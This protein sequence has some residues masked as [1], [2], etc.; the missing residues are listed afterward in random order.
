MQVRNN[1]AAFFS[2]IDL[3]AVAA[4]H[5]FLLGHGL[6]S[7]QKFVTQGGM[8][9]VVQSLNVRFWNQ[10]NVNRRF[11]MDIAKGGNGF[12]LPNQLRFS[13]AIGNFAKQTVGIHGPIIAKT[14]PM[15]PC[16]RY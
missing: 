13:L 1:L 15:S 5:A 9:E 14:R 12:V 2:H 10:Q 3:N 8:I 6:H 4:G 11:W 16:E 7:L